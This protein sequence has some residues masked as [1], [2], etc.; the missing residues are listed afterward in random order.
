MVLNEDAMAT[1][2]AVLAGV[3]TRFLADRG[4]LGERP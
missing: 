1:G 4:D 2:I 3:A